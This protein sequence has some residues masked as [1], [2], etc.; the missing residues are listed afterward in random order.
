MGSGA[1]GAAPWL[2][3]LKIF[4]ERPHGYEAATAVAFQVGVKT[5]SLLASGEC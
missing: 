3:Y 1:G 2:F 4:G 5:A